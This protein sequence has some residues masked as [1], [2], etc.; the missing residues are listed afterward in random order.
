MDLI[1]QEFRRFHEEK[2]E[3]LETIRQQI[4]QIWGIGK[5]EE[6]IQNTEEAIMVMLKLHTK[7]EDKAQQIQTKKKYL[8]L[9]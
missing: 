6:R 1:L 4:G 9:W 7:L 5:A 8:L 2:K 3:Q